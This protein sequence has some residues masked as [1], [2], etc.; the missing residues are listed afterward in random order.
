VAATFFREKGLFA[1]AGMKEN[2]RSVRDA[3]RDN[4]AAR[5]APHRGCPREG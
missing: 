2:Q 1:R 3:C 5:M 4:A